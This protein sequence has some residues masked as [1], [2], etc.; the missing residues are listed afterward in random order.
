MI[1]KKKEAYTKHGE[2]ALKERMGDGGP[3]HNP[4]DIFEPFLGDSLGGSS[5]GGKGILFFT[6]KVVY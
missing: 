1:Q 2:D 6:L 5:F 4:F 3:S